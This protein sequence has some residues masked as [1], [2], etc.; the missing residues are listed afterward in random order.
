MKKYLILLLF[1][2]LACTTEKIEQHIIDSGENSIENPERLTPEE[3]EYM[4]YL[5]T[6]ESEMSTFWNG[7]NSIR[8][9]PIFIQTGDDEGIFINPPNSMRDNSRAILNELT[10]FETLYL[11]RNDEIKTFIIEELNGSLYDFQLEYEGIPIYAYN[12]TELIDFN[13]YH[14]YKN[15]DGFYNVSVF[16]HELFHFYSLVL[17]EELF[18]DEDS[19]YVSNEFPYNEDTLPLILLLYDVMIDAYHLDTTIQKTNYLKYYV[20]IQHKLN[21]LDTSEN[22]LVRNYLFVR[23]KTEGAARYIEVFST[24]YTINNNTIEDP[25]HGFKEYSENITD[26]WGVL[27]VYDFRMPY[28]TGAGAINLLN[29]LDCPNWEE[30]FLIPENTPFDIA[31]DCLN[32]NDSQ[33]DIFLEEVKSLYDWDALVERSEFLLS[34]Q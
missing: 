15:R 33:L 30:K 1:T 27:D 14:L 5:L 19:I 13:F 25:T 7:F 2:F 20:S 28:H 31:Y 32:M 8:D 26:W 4:T 34:L 3:F 23:E 16:L 9:E 24:L 6:V 11:Y 17:N 10:D 18:V 21:S 12:I 29:E 22:N